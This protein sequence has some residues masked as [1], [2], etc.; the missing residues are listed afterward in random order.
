MQVKRRSSMVQ[1]LAGLAVVILALIGVALTGGSHSEPARAAQGG[2]SRALARRALGSMFQDDPHLIYASTATVVRTLDILKGLGVNQIRATVVWKGVAPDPLSSTAPGRFNGADPAAYPAASWLPYDR[3]DEL[4]QARG[5]TLNFNV[6]AP[7]PR[8]AVDQGAPSSHYAD[9]WMPSA[10]R[11]GQFV[12]AL[13]QRYSGH[14]I[15]PGAHGPLPRVSFWSIWNEPNQPGWLAPQWRLSPHGPVMEAPVLYRRYVDA[16]FGA[17]LRTGHSPSTDTVLVGDLAPEGCVAGQVCQGGVYQRPEWPIPPL[18]FLRALYCLGPNYRPL[19]GGPAAALGCPTSPDPQAF[20][21]AH[22]GLFRATGFAHHPYSFFLPPNVGMSTTAFAPLSN[23]GRLERT[24]DSIFRAY[25]V[26]RR[27][28]I[29]L[30]EYGYETNPPNPYRGVSPQLQALYLNE[31][32]YLAW[33]D[34]RVRTLNQF[35]LYD[36]PP[37]RA[38]P[39]GSPGYWSTFQTGL[40][41]ANGRPKPSFSAYRLPLFLPPPP[42]GSGRRVLVWAMLRAAPPGTTQRAEIQWRRSSAGTFRTIRRVLVNDPSEV[43]SETVTVPGPGQLRV[44][45]TSP[46]GQVQDSRAASVRAG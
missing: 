32:E 37:N 14:Y 1:V 26:A 2:S 17:L 9:H 18:P 43:L 10:T 40:L 41:Y 35:L 29:Y 34:P 21:A 46:A 31:A 19:S 45:W 5:L 6:T 44:Q 12:Q 15:P 27:V 38:F 22:P 24:L 11:F 8:W 36:Y 20:V 4:A 28:P 16:A 23:L 33:R 39:P 25:G 30:T 42:P 3:L 7:A 13:G